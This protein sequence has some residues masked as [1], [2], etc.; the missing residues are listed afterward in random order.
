MPRFGMDMCEILNINLKYNE[1]LAMLK[2]N[3]WYMENSNTCLEYPL[4]WVTCNI[5]SRIQY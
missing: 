5:I 2:A 4:Y 1:T 3:L